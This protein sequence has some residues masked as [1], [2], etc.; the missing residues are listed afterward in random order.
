VSDRIHI[1]APDAT[2]ALS[3]RHR[4]NALGIEADMMPHGEGWDVRT[5]ANGFDLDDVLKAVEEWIEDEEIASSRVRKGSKV[6]V[7]ERAGALGR[8]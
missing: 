8:A 1:Q 4:L 3:L 5:L 6:V 7:L 2:S